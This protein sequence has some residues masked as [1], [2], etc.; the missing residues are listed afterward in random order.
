MKPNGLS[1]DSTARFF[2]GD[3]LVLCPMEAILPLIRT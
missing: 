2:E 1:N 3:N